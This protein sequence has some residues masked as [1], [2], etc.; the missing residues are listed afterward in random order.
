[1]GV[2]LDRLLEVLEHLDSMEHILRNL[3]RTFRRRIFQALLSA[4]SGFNSSFIDEESHTLTLSSTEEKKDTQSVLESLSSVFGFLHAHLPVRL[5]SALGKMLSKDLVGT[6]IREWLTPSVPLC[7]TDL[8]KTYSIQ[9]TVTDLANQMLS[10]HWPGHDELTSWLEGL[11]HIWLDK[12]RSS[13]LDAVRKAFKAQ[14]GANRQVKRIERQHVSPQDEALAQNG[15]HNDNADSVEQQPETATTLIHPTTQD[16]ED[17]SGWDF[18]EDGEKNES[19]APSPTK[20][21]GDMED[22]TDAWGW[23]EDNA[24]KTREDDPSLGLHRINTGPQRTSAEHREVTLTET[25]TITDLPDYLLEIV[26]CEVRDSEQMKSPEYAAFER[27][28]ASACL[29]SLPTLILAMFRATA[30]AHYSSAIPSGN[31]HLYNDCVYLVEK[32]RDLAKSTSSNQLLDECN[33]LEKFAKSAYA[34][35]MDL[36]RTVLSDILDG[37]QGFVNCTRFPYSAECETAVS[38]AVDRLRA[39]HRDWS[40]ILSRSALLQSIGSLLSSI[41]EK[42][43]R[44]VEDMEDISE[45]ESQRLTAFCNQISA[46]EDLFVSEQAAQGERADTEAVPLTAVYVS[47]WLRFQYLANIL[48]SSLVD[49][50]YLW[51]EGELSLEFTADEVVEL[52]EALFA[53]SSHRRSAIAEIRRS[54]P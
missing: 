25:Y 11:P 52:I 21:S 44:D 45:A 5:N 30:P 14:R 28:S 20:T 42:M 16:E 18:E 12:R 10:Y 50:K 40:S 22:T 34:R 15:F 19:A 54:R 32:L 2:T 27:T 8:L 13:A 47:N 6:L 38:S 31:M 26:S 37:A 35:E 53:E 39:V 51:T 29:R 17:L 9:T 24:D 23:D 41:I 36:Q 46:L 7:L 33:V 1:M 4:A 48:E 49:I 3:S 43:I